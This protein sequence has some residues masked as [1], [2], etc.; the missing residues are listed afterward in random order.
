MRASSVSISSLYATAAFLCSLINNP[1]HPIVNLLISLSRVLYRLCCAYQCA[2]VHAIVAGNREETVRGQLWFVTANFYGYKNKKYNMANFM[3]YTALATFA[4]G[5]GVAPGSRLQA[6]A[7]DDSAQLVRLRAAEDNL[8]ANVCG[9]GHI[10]DA[11]KWYG[12]YG[13]A[14]D[15]CRGLTFNI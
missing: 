12:Q 5:Q 4:F 13:A 15:V 11:T 7:F 6:F 3:D 1:V 9:V 10:F 8:G 2:T 14:V